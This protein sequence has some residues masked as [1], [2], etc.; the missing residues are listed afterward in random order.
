MKKIFTVIA[1]FCSAVSFG[2]V[3]DIIFHPQDDN[4]FD[5]LLMDTTFAYGQLG[6]L[7]GDGTASVWVYSMGDYIYRIDNIPFGQTDTIHAYWEYADMVANEYEGDSDPENE[8]EIPD[9]SG[10]DGEVLTTN[11]TVT[12]WMAV[13]QPFT[14]SDDLNFTSTAAGAF[15]DLLITVTGAVAGSVVSLGIPPAAIVGNCQYM[16]WV[17]DADEVTV[18]FINLDS[19][20]LDPGEETFNVLV[21]P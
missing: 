1:L 13:S 17:S 18:R 19:T 3:R 14:A 10:H 7:N 20:S 5:P 16:A 9:Q 12:S 15:A 6:Y 2:Q 21:F 11:G 8:I 4:Y